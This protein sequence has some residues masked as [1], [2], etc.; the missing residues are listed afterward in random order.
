MTVNELNDFKYL[1]NAWRT[2]AEDH[3]KKD[4]KI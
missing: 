1:Q 3:F 2:V 4:K